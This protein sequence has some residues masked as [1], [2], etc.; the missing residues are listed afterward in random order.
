MN[1]L[2]GEGERRDTGG[3]TRRARVGWR[4]RWEESRQGEPSQPATVAAPPYVA[5]AIATVA[6]APAIPAPATT[7]VPVPAA[8][9]TASLIRSPH[10]HD[11]PASLPFYSG[12][13]VCCWWRRVYARRRVSP[14]RSPC[15]GRPTYSGRTFY[16]GGLVGTCRSSVSPS[17]SPPLT[18]PWSRAPY[19]ACPC[20]YS[21]PLSC[22]LCLRGP[23]RLAR[24]RP[25]LLLCGLR[26]CRLT[27]SQLL[28]IS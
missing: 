5:I 2:A 23:A 12:R 27:C 25:C 28:L 18:R 4:G 6:F 21:R 3:A 1:P 24:P 10:R 15:P 8:A 16:S 14:G 13:P 26:L 22:P 9:P 7:A 20:A 19:L 11:S 17:R